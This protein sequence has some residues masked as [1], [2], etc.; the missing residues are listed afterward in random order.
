[1]TLWVNLRFER[2]GA[3]QNVHTFRKVPH[4]PAGFSAGTR[5]APSSQWRRHRSRVHREHQSEGV[6]FEVVGSASRVRP[7]FPAAR[8]F[9]GAAGSTSWSLGLPGA[10]SKAAAATGVDMFEER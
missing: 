1:V 4:D 6:P 2:G 8:P 10:G 7:R 3:G 5:Y 9:G